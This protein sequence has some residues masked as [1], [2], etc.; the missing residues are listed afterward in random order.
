[1]EGAINL[2]PVGS[3]RGVYRG[4]D[5]TAITAAA[6]RCLRD[7]H[8]VRSFVDLRTEFEVDRSGPPVG[9]FSGG[10]RWIR[11][12]VAS[13]KR[14]PIAG[15]DPGPEAYCCYYLDILEDS[16]EQLILA[17]R[18]V[19]AAP[20]APLAFGCYAGK[21]RTG[22][23]AAILLEIAGASQTDV[24]ADYAASE[25]HLLAATDYF[26][27][28]WLARGRTAAQYAHRLATS[29]TTIELLYRALDGRTFL[30]HMRCRGLDPI[31][32]AELAAR[33]RSAYASAL[34]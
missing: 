22:L 33:L 28:N 31:L 29:A 21:D 30:S 11:S 34:S 9:L 1:M 16:A 17:L 13:R 15:P 18:S 12:P 19:A 27:P 14:G 2:R 32:E 4:G 7:R 10:I 3:L 6:A 5:P 20:P 8:G 26:A 24:V 25:R 23:L